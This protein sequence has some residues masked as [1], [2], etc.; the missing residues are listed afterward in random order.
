MNK[1]GFTLAELLAVLVI[2]SILAL[3]TTTAVMKIIKSSRDKLY[4]DQ[5]K[6]IEKASEK[7]ALDNSDLVGY[8]TPYCLSMDDLLKS[9]HIEKDTLIDPRD[10]SDIDGYVKITYDSSYKQFEYEYMETC[11]TN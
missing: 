11:S 4:D 9:G 7:W 5:I 8:T 10:E 6:L 3:I 1:K 2:L